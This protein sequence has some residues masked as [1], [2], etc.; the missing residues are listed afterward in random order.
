MFLSVTVEIVLKEARYDR[1]LDLVAE[2]GEVTV[3]ELNDALRVSEATIRRDLDQLSQQGRLRRS[4]GG[5]VR[6]V[7]ADREPP[8]ALREAALRAEK[9]RIGRTAAALVQPGDRVFLCSGTTVET[10]PRHLRDVR[11]LTV[12]TNSLPVVNQLV[13]R[14][15]IELIVIGGVVRHT[16][17]S[18]I[19]Q[20]AER[21]IAELRVDTVFMGCVALDPG[22]GLTA[23][24]IAEASTD[25]AILQIAR[26]RVILADHTKFRRSG[27]IAIAP[28]EWVH[29]VVTDSIDAQL[30]RA[31]R[32]LGPD[33][34]VAG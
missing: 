9:E 25:R 23:E 21:M 6:V 18:M 34:L 1:I 8:L 11:D 30:E 24:S 4:H 3:A 14:P 28:L 27:T 13:D 19:S 31:I 15:E 20:L 10:L 32:E 29:V 26:R 12:V 17:R 5:A 16:E 2:R 33:V 22:D 7:G